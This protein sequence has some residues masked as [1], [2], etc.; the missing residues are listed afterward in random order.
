M[1]LDPLFKDGGDLTGS[2]TGS[3]H[4][5]GDKGP[6]SRGS[7]LTGLKEGLNII[8]GFINTYN[9]YNAVKSTTVNVSVRRH[10]GAGSTLN[11]R[12]LNKYFEH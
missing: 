3:S 9:L 11:S 12:T 6:G 8:T 7:Y 2:S 4:C 10:S 1:S 5:A